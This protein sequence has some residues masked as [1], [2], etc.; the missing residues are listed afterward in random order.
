MWRAVHAV[1]LLMAGA[2]Y[3]AT[4]PAVWTLAR[5]AHFEVYSQASAAGAQSALAW[6]EQLRALVTAQTGL[7]LEAR[8]AIRVIAFRSEADYNPFRLHATAD[9]YYVGSESRDY[10]V[11]PSLDESG[12]RTAAH[13]YAH[14]ALRAAGVHLPVWLNEGLADLLSTIRIEN[15]IAR[16]GGELPGRMQTLRSHPWTPLGGLA[17]LPTDG[18]QK[19]DRAAADLFYAES[20]ALTEMLALAPSYSARFPLLVGKLAGGAAGKD[21]IE[22]VYGKPIEAIEHDL[23]SWVAHGNTKPMALAAPADASP[24]VEVSQVAT[25]DMNLI[26]AGM[27]LAAGKLDRSEAIYQD[28]QRGAPDSPDVSAGL[29]AIALAR[30][31]TD[32][33]RRLW[34]R[35]L[36]LGL[37]DPAICYRYAVLLDQAGIGGEE[38]RTA[39]ER[40]LALDPDLDDARYKLALLE[41]NTGLY[42]A[43]V[44]DL[45][46]IRH[47][48]ADRAF[49]YWCAM[50]DA[51]TGLGRGAEAENAA[52]R[53]AEHATSPAER[54]K[55]SQLAFIARSH[56]EV[57]FARDENGNQRLITTRVP[58]S[59]SDFN[60]FIEPSD[61]IRTVR[62]TL[63]DVGCD[64][65][66][67][68][69]SIAG[70]D[71]LVKVAIPDPRRVRMRNAPP[72]FTCG[73]QDG[74]AVTVDYDA[75]TKVARGITF[76]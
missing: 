15:R 17:A 11:L 34:K 54:N 16:L 13:E 66:V 14:Y 65:D 56:L 33:A 20:W 74:A 6:F 31:D 7:K 48:S 71:G 25:A 32:E 58:D 28:L 52:H 61:D 69:F 4:P 8:P 68:R 50:A 43:A 29:G 53:A 41:A 19:Y 9:A 45:R 70:P 1:G 67:L 38:L 55:A 10:I 63:R 12:L 64:G 3:A 51:L 30:H 73:P 57:Q 42:D 62:G 2:L 22:S 44:A 46:A 59:A 21:A 72:E 40:T 23:H 76:Q 47:V 5:N 26:L 36:D 18:P 24:A 27:L 35:A 60:P 39:L 49:T 75:A 37:K